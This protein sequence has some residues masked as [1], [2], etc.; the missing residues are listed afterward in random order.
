MSDLSENHTD[1]GAP[2]AADHPERAAS[3]LLISLCTFNERENIERLIP[4]LLALIPSAEILVVDDNSPDGTGTWAQQV[5][6]DNPRVHVVHR[7]QKLG[8]GTA[9]IAAI[10][11]AIDHDYDRLLNMDADFSH[12]PEDA[13]GVIDCLERVDVGVGSRYVDGG[14]VVGWGLRRHL[15]SRCI[16]LYARTLLGLTTR[17]NSGSFRCY[18]ISKLKEIDLDRF[19]A[20]GYA[21]QE[22]LMYRCRRVGCTFEEHPIL[23]EDRRYG[24]SK[25][26]GREA[27][28][29][30][31]ILFRLSIDRLLGTSVRPHRPAA[32]AELNAATGAADHAPTV[33]RRVQ[34]PSSPQ[35]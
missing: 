16:N 28:A 31:W 9:T 19:R 14:G 1:R 35:S 2:Q 11:Y 13:P 15:M 29:A 7:R 17:D 21:V 30:L 8:L 33:T 22:E 26:N 24:Q 3:R 4:R 18:R 25:I 34:H 27:L 23:F 32:S 20:R 6:D 10:R 5:S 12:R